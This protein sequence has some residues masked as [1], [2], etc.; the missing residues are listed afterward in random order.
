VSEDWGWKRLCA[1]P[2]VADMAPMWDVDASLKDHISAVALCC[3]CPVKA[4]CQAQAE[5]RDAA[6][7]L[8]SGLYAGRMWGDKRGPKTV[9]AWHRTHG[10]TGDAKVAAVGD[11]RTCKADDCDETFRVTA[12]GKHKLYHSPECS[13]VHRNARA[14]M[15]LK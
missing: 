8:G 3:Q 11:L 10:T 2:G 5:R 6:K 7:T 4:Q 12:N 1:Q 14:R 13:R 15:D 9:W